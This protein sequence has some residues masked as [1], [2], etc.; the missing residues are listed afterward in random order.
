MVVESGSPTEHES[1]R[2]WV[3]MGVSG[4]GK[5]TIGTALAQALGVPFLEGDAFHP[6][7]NVAKMSAGN[8]LDDSDRAGWLQALAAE[9]GSA[10]G[11]GAGLVL[12]CSALK[13]RYRDTLRQ[14]DPA[15]RF[16]HLQGPASLIAERMARR[17]DHYMPPSLLESQLR[18]LEALQD[19]EA[20]IT[21]DIT[22]PPEVLV[23]RITEKD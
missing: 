21:L 2:R 4:C 14:A 9:I 1:A 7:G 12:S 15:L 16:V 11:R 8:P 18:D 23:G 6:P 3:V 17:T 5:S 10:R 13:R 20:G 19:D 22:L